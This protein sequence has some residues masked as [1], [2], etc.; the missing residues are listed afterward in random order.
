[1][2]RFCCKT[3]SLTLEIIPTFGIAGNPS[4][5]AALDLL[6]SAYTGDSPALFL[7]P[8]SSRGLVD[9]AEVMALLL[10]DLGDGDRAISAAETG[11]P[12]SCFFPRDGIIIPRRKPLGDDRG[13]GSRVLA[14]LPFP[15]PPPPAAAREVVEKALLSVAPPEEC[16]PMDGASGSRSPSLPR[17]SPAAP[18]PPR[19]W[20]DHEPPH[21]AA[22]FVVLAFLAPPAPPSLS[23]AAVS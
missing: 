13:F 23:P 7:T 16:F 1:M 2:F 4:Y 19:C 12:L 20:E 14:P 11:A 6:S 3:L 22:M 5:P 9:A 21:R 8:A 15:P 10:D 17:S 18:L